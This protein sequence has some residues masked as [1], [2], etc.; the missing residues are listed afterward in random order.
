MDRFIAES[1]IEHFKGLLATEQNEARRQSI[2]RLLADEEG[3]L[4]SI[5]QKEA[6]ALRP[7]ASGQ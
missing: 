2:L 5:R 6:C 7:K 4:R 3:K 1:N